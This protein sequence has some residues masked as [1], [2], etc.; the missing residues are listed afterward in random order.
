MGY[1]PYAEFRKLIADEGGT[2]IES[3]IFFDNVRDWQEY[4]PVNDKIRETLESDERGRF[5]LLNNGVTIV[6]KEINSVSTK[7]TLTDYQ[8]VNGCQ[9]SNVL[10]DQDGIIDER[11]HIPLRLIATKDE[12]VKDQIIEATNS[13]T[14]VK[15]EQYFARLTFA[16]KLEAFFDAQDDNI[17][18]HFERRDGQYDRSDVQKTKVVTT[19]NLI[20]SYAA[21]YLEEPHR[22]TRG[23]TGLRNRVGSEIFAETHQLA[24]Y[25]S[26]AYALYALEA[27]FRSGAIDRAYKPARYHFLLALRL[28]FSPDRPE[29]PNARAGAAS[30]EKFLAALADPAQADPLFAEARAAIDRATSGNLDR[31]H[32]RTVGVTENILA[33][34]GREKFPS[35]AISPKAVR[36][37]DLA[38]SETPIPE[39][40]GA[41]PFAP[42]ADLMKGATGDEYS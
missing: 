21:I 29:A 3:S 25:F 13:Q 28:A 38:K 35:G 18:L 16:R 20:R 37:E 30:A 7:F 22:T 4:N 33:Y 39:T 15:A 23:Y 12:D 10:F 34:F 19:A 31:D 42:S 41:A 27:R 36:N 17:R 40:S 6:A 9:T 11:V 32:V 2:E 8:I 1:V 26:A 14:T 24:P 5:V